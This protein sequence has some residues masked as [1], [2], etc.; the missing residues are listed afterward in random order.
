M[1]V[2]R[3]KD[4]PIGR[5]TPV[6]VEQHGRAVDHFAFVPDPLPDSV[7]L[8]SE[9]Y[10]AIE[11]A[12]TQLGLLEGAARGL[13]N[14]YVVT[15][16][17]VRKEAQ[18]TSA[19]EGTYSTLE[20]LFAVD[21]DEDLMPASQALTDVWNY[22]QAAEMGVAALADRPVSMRL[23]CELHAVLMRGSEFESSSGALRDSHVAIGPRGTPITEARFVPPPPGPNLGDLFSDWERWNYREDSIPLLARVAVSHYQFETI[24]PFLDGNGRLGRLIVVLLLIELG[25]LSDHYLVLSPYLERRRSRYQDFLAHTSETGDFDPWVRFFAEAVAAEAEAARS[26]V[27]A[28]LEYPSSIVARLRADGR[29]GAVIDLANLLVENPV[30][31]VRRAAELLDVSYQSANRVIGTLV[32]LGELREVTGG[33]YGRLFA[34]RRVFDILHQGST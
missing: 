25:P 30:L 14:P 11:R 34:A 24:H 10:A 29:K 3:F 33:S 7:T 13:E 1:D 18:S 12:A 16:P 22:V 5:L 6:R 28:L 23:I 9:T 19:L 26:R 17:L 32:A 15:R 31:S 27:E 20:D 8:R 21:V 2:E 4:S